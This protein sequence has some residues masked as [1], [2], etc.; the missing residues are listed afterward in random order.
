MLAAAQGIGWI[1]TTD[2]AVHAALATALL[3]L[4]VGQLRRRLRLCAGRG[5]DRGRGRP[6]SGTGGPGQSAGLPAVA[7][8]GRRQ[9][10]GRERG[11][12]LAVGRFRAGVHAGP[13]HHLGAAGEVGPLAAHRRP[14]AIGRIGARRP[15]KARH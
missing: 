3:V 4:A 14:P 5:A 2:P 15:A 12:V 8:L 7:G 1:F 11:T 13:R 6:V 9:Q 10:A